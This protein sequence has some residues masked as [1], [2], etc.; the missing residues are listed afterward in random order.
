MVSAVEEAELTPPLVCIDVIDHV[1]SASVPKSQLV[2]AVAVNVQV[3]F[4]EPAFVAV[5]VTVLPLVA[6]P[7]EIV[8]VLS[9]VTPSLFDEPLSDAVATA[10]VAVAEGG[11]IYV[12]PPLNVADCVSVLVT[13]TSCAPA[14]PAG[15]V[16]VIEVADTTI[17]FVH[18]APPTV[19]VAPA[20]KFDPVIVIDVPPAL[21]PELTETLD[22]VGAAAKGVTLTALDATD[23]PAE[24][25]AFKYT[26]YAVPPVRPGIVIGDVASAGLSAVYV[27]PS[28][29]YS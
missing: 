13:T 23:R 17:T 21:V 5:T 28:N 15:V 16:Q 26:V 22:T 7:T 25:R 6:L 29:E 8:G 12:K 3:T 20:R 14:L 2:C 18:A 24:L 9:E 10:G 19:T 11:A 1:P 27:T 4:A